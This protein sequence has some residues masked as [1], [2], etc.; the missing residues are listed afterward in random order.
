MKDAFEIIHQPVLSEK[1][2]KATQ[3]NKYTFRVHLDANKIEIAKAV[4]EIYKK[5]VVKVN[6]LIVKGEHRRVRG[7]L[8]G[9]EP[10]YKKAIVTLAPGDT[11]ELFEG[12]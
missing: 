1:S 5:K 9:K 3:L 10:D 4:E 8:V 12:V 7:R 6:T 2:M 11:I